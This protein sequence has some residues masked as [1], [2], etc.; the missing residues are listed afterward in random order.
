MSFDN[1]RDSNANESERQKYVLELLTQYEAS[2]LAF[3]EEKV[4]DVAREFSVNALGEFIMPSLPPH[5]RKGVA[6]TLEIPLH[7]RAPRLEARWFISHY[8]KDVSMCPFLLQFAKTLTRSNV[9][10]SKILQ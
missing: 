4:L 5:L 10:I 6:H 2:Y 1:Y 3:G 8:A 9:C 7:W